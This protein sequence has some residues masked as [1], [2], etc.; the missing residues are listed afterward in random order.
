MDYMN[1]NCSPSKTRSK[2][3]NHQLSPSHLLTEQQWKAAG[4]YLRHCT[5]QELP[6]VQTTIVGTLLQGVKRSPGEIKI[7]G[8]IV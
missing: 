6:E 1:N 3:K 5:M 4:H 8:F 2:K 7:S